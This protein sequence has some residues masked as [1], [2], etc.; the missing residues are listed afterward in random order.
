MR[1]SP[2]ADRF[3]PAHILTLAGILGYFLPL[4]WRDIFGYFTHDDGLNL[5]TYTATG[6]FRTGSWFGLCW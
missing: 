4:S 5:F 3:I 1:M 6:T 2:T